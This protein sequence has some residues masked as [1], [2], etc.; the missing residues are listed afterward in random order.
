[1]YSL[2]PLGESLKPIIDAMHEWGIK[3]ISEH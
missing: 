1:E 3:H 2:T